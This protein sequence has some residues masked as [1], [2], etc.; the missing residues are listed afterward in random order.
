[1]KPICAVFKQAVIN[2]QN[3]LKS[4][5]EF[6]LNPLLCA[7]RVARFGLCGK[8]SRVLLCL[9]NRAAVS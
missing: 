5:K 9:N 4:R 7:R 2:T 6:D 8:T 3:R 1:M